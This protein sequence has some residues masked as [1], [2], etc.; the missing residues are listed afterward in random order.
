MNKELLLLFE[1]HTDTLLEQ[2]KRK[3]QE[4]LEFKLNKQMKIYRSILQKI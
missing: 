4:S 3:P 1:K 2:T